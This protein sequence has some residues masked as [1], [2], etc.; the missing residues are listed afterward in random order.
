[1]F[2]FL[3]YI[4]KTL[5]RHRARTILTVSGS[6]VAL[7]VFSFVGS[8]QQ[9]M[10]DLQRR[11]EAKQSLIIFQ[12]NKFC[13]ATSHLPQDYESKIRRLD[14][15]R[16]VVPI[17]VFTNNCR[18]SLDVIVFYGVPPAKLRGARDFELVSGSWTDFEQHQDAAV[19]G[20]AVASRRGLEAGDKFSIGD[21]TVQVA[22]VYRSNDP[23]EENY[24]YSHL[25]FLQRGSNEDLVGTVTQHEVLLDAG[26]D[27]TAKSEEID[28]IF[29]GGPVE[30]D[31]RPKGVFQAK[32]LGDL[33]QLI[34]LAWYLG[35]A[36]VGLVLAL[37]ATTTVMSVQ[38]RI[39]EHAVLQTLGFTGGRV[40]QL[41]LSESMLLS[42]AGGV[43]GIG[44]A[45]LA[46][47]LSHLS[48]GAEAVTIAFRPSWS[49][50]ASGV[51]TSLI[52]GILA[53]IA[54][55]WHAARTEIVPSLRV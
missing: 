46:L 1:M 35:F 34:A 47:Q 9:G 26:V 31:T 12:A 18:A 54:P 44:A 5:W 40:F 55:G 50:A 37:V 6:A 19:I 14:G 29:R 39:Q 36:C 17:Q 24:I 21:L 28:E 4:L 38:D 7:F 8:V 20:R 48:V 53:G 16:E 41:V 23:A 42:V 27:A 13:P 30:T 22:G 43:L 52:V 32:S 51:F 49:L 11:Q 10:D 25:D 2:K 45:M 33:T 15:V 3:P